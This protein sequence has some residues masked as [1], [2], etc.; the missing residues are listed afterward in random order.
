MMDQRRHLGEEPV[1]RHL[2]DNDRIA[3]RLAGLGQARLAGL[4]HHPYP[5]LPSSRGGQVAEAIR[6]GGSHAAET[7]EHRRRRLT[8]A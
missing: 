8:T 1:V 6:A 7:D 2:A 3:G 4:D 5:G